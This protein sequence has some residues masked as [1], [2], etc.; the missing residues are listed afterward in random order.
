MRDKIGPSV[1]L[2]ID[3]ES[4]KRRDIQRGVEKSFSKGI[5]A[6]ITQKVKVKEGRNTTFNEFIG[7]ENDKK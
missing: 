4:P 2:D 6:R 1:S 7:E 3:V 5:L